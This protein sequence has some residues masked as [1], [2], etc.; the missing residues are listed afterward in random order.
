MGD[1]E[2][3]RSP[4]NE[5]LKMGREKYSRAYDAIMSMLSDMHPELVQMV[6]ELDQ[7]YAQ[8]EQPSFKERV[9]ISMELLRTMDG[10][11]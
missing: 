2:S 4:R 5:G 7:R 9:L 8:D 6:D 1:G 3:C 11:Q 10:S